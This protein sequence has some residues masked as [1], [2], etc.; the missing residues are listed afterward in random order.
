[1]SLLSQ[2]LTRLEEFLW[3]IE[4]GKLGWGKRFLFALGRVIH[5][6]IRRCN[7]HQ[8][9]LRASALTLFSLLAVVPVLATLFGIAKGFGLAEMVEAQIREAFAT[10]EQVMTMLVSFSKNSLEHAKGG[11]IAGIGVLILLWTVVRM[12]GNVEEALNT[13]WSTKRQRT[14]LR[15][16]TDYLFLVILLRLLLVFSS[17]ATVALTDGVREG[18]LELGLYPDLVATILLSAQF[19]PALLLGFGFAFIYAF[20]PNTKVDPIAALIGGLTAAVLFLFTQYLYVQFQFAL[21]SY[22]AIYGSFAAL[23]LFLIW[24]QAGWIL[25]LFGAELTRAIELRDEYEFEPFT[26]EL[27][28]NALFEGVERISSALK[29]RL[30]NG[31][32]GASLEELS[33]TLALP[34]GTVRSCCEALQKACVLTI[35]EERRYVPTIPTSDLESGKVLEH[36]KDAGRELPV[37]KR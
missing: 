11:L 25:I 7:Q 3:C 8:I 14:M 9:F 22:G 4:R 34:K 6:A 33:E 27:S 30:E 17:S 36:L 16:F 19:I 37:A 35:D 23:P 10:Q 12:I 15:K 1:M 2:Q 5:L 20:L 18:L 29:E 31:S 24:L 13:I 28:L 32:G 26:R 21:A